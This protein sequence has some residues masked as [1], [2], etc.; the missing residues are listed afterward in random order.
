M[1]NWCFTKII[2]H[3]EKNEIKDF[4]EK[5][6][7]WTAE[8]LRPNDFKED[9][10]G[11]ILIGAGLG[12]RINSETHSL[13]CRGWITYTEYDE[14]NA[15]E[16]EA[17][18]YVDTE[19]AWCPMMLMWVAVL[20]VLMYDTIGFSYIAEEPGMELYEICDP[21]GDFYERYYV[22]VWVEGEDEENEELMRLYDDRYYSSD[23]DLKTSLQK[24]LNSEEDD[25]KTLIEKAESYDFK[26]KGSYISVHEYEIVDAP[27][28]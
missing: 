13:R 17:F 2:F 21:Y 24:F 10:L 6:E 19:T 16:G 26:H 1:S 15:D 8:P 23:E 20:D 7:K 25:L 18:L 14:E 27:G 28:Q 3:G 22:D 12:D 9:W 5:I 4:Y 11:N